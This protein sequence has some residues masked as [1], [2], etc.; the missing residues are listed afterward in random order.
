[1]S[2]RELTQHLQTQYLNRMVAVHSDLRGFHK[3]LTKRINPKTLKLIHGAHVKPQPIDIEPLARALHK[4]TL[5][6]SR[7][8]ARPCR[9]EPQETESIDVYLSESSSNRSIGR[10]VVPKQV[11]VQSVAKKN[12]F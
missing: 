8:L 11:M 12:S 3:L 4:V 6:K 5:H 10:L 2:S 7:S 1:M 9:K